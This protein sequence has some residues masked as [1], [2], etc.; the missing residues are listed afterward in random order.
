M[1][2]RRTAAAVAA[3]DFKNAMRRLAAGVT[4]VATAGRKDGRCGLTATA[5]CSLSADPPQLLV[6]VN[7]DT[8][9]NA[10]IAR[11]GRF[12]VNVLATRHKA[13]ALRFAGVTGV[14]GDERFARGDWI[15]AAT[16]AP[17]LADALAYFDCRLVDRVESGTHTVFIGEVRAAHSRKNG[18]P[19][20]YAAGAFQALAKKAARR[21]D[22][23][24]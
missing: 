2:R 12:S 15:A 9:P 5:V 10:A 23:A 11:A 18:A 8:A 14:Q 22:R 19:L 3:A 21:S 13:L 17:V 24:K 16:G 4:I 1:K 6:C 20:L 7:R